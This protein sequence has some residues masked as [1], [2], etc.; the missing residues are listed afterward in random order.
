M[1]DFRT[2][3]VWPDP[4][5]SIGGFCVQIGRKCCWEPTGP[6]LVAFKELSVKIEELFR[7]HKELIIECEEISWSLKFL[8]WMVGRTEKT[9]KPTIV[10]ASKSKPSRL[11]ALH[12]VKQS[13]LLAEYPGIALKAL[14]VMPAIPRASSLQATEIRM[15]QPYQPSENDA[16]NPSVILHASSSD[17]PRTHDA[18]SRDWGEPRQTSN[19]NPDDSP[20]KSN[21]S[22]YA[23]GSL[24]NH[25]GAPL[26]VGESN[27]A[28][29]G[30]VV[31]VNRKHYGLTAHHSRTLDQSKPLCYWKTATL[32]FDDDD[33]DEESDVDDDDFDVVT[34][35]ASISSA[36]DSEPLSSPDSDSSHTP[37]ELGAQDGT[38]EET[39][40]PI[41]IKSTETVP[42]SPDLRD[43]PM[44]K[45]G[46]L[47]SSLASSDLD[48]NLF[49]LQTTDATIH[50]EINIQSEEACSTKQILIQGVARELT[51][52]KIFVAT[53]TTGV[54]S[55]SMQE[56]PHFLQIENSRHLQEVWAVRLDREILAGDSGSW[57]IDASTGE[58]C[59]HIVASDPLTGLGYVVPAHKVFDDIKKHLGSAPVLPS[60]PSL[61]T[62]TGPQDPLSH[63]A[64]QIIRNAATSAH[65]SIQLFTEFLIS[66]SF[67]S[68]QAT[69][70]LAH[71]IDC[72]CE[73]TDGADAEL[74][75]IW[76]C[77]LL[78]MELA[79]AFSNSLMA[80]LLLT[81]ML[82]H[83]YSIRLFA[84]VGYYLL[85]VSRQFLRARKRE[86]IRTRKQDATFQKALR[87]TSILRRTGIE[88]LR[89]LVIIH[90]QIH[91]E[92]TIVR[93]VPRSGGEKFLPSYCE[94]ARW[95]MTFSTI[96]SK[97]RSGLSYLVHIPLFIPTA[98]REAFRWLS[99]YQD[100]AVRF[101]SESLTP[102]SPFFCLVQCLGSPISAATSLIWE[103]SI[104]K[105]VHEILLNDQMIADSVSKYESWVMNDSSYDDL[106]TDSMLQRSEMQPKRRSYRDGRRLWQPLRERHINYSQYPSS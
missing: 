64:K 86:F 15:L 45:I 90:F 60:H 77:M 71:V 17:H 37:L 57:V 16:S 104:R 43:L 83:V 31:S 79:I 63:R 32:K 13:N 103:Y 82:H 102:S 10:F 1:L 65:E 74:S 93:S 84:F 27:T 21:D 19:E 56:S 33:S 22:I 49:P 42:L 94:G 105:K 78:P 58:L 89:D 101:A 99:S 24:E 106:H 34:S 95:R 72:L 87:A 98:F 46:S 7:T 66:C 12:L 96:I 48:Y 9:A 85:K 18:L 54:V 35:R 91:V 73:Y 69:K 2:Q 8:M 76:S 5:D 92:A 6:A 50:N 62:S 4:E 100:T 75:F 51:A 88:S 23:I 38:A 29:L 40:S 14:E 28:T 11:K 59:G 39:S 55:G 53:G 30:G 3:P 61:E 36:S 68:N 70:E 41:H 20:L 67:I 52:R 81:S 80:V 47:S 97:L 44:L 25:C 26:L